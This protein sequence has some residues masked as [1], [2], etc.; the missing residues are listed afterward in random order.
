MKRPLGVELVPT[1]P[2]RRK[3]WRRHLR[4]GLGLSLC[5]LALG[6]G[7]V[8][9]L[10][11][12]EAEGSRADR[13]SPQELALMGSLQISQLR[14][15]DPDPSNRFIGNE[16]AARLGK[17]VFNDVRFSSNGKVSCASCHNPQGQFEDGRPRGL[18]V[19]EGLRRTMPS[20]GMAHSAWFFWDGRKDSLWAQALGPLEDAREHGGNRLQY[21]RLLSQHYAQPYRELFGEL[22]RLDGLPAHASPQG[23]EAERAAWA[24]I[25]EAR[26]QDINRMYANLG[27][28][29]A[30]FEARLQYGESRVDR[31]IAATLKGGSGSASLLNE[32]EMAGLRLFIGRGQC[33]TCHAGPLMTD[34]HFHNT[35]IPPLNPAQ[36]ERGRV[37]GLR[38]ALADEFNC[39]GPYSDAK[40]QQCEELRFANPK[41]PHL[42]G[43]FKTP[44][45]RNVALR[46]PYM[47]AGQFATLE[48][49][50]AHYAR[51][52]EAELGHSELREL[53]P[54]DL[55][56]QE[57][58]QLLSFLR[59]LSGP[60]LEKPAVQPA[61]A[62]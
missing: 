4:S 30:A 56:P 41:D 24:T 11:H 26:R 61:P 57:Q 38:A 29:I 53:K 35:G 58:A 32:Q 6:G 14:S 49:V 46:P 44:S 54:R 36:P 59:A 17:Q 10:A 3:G 42:V 23:S 43:A 50:L 47:H 8:L 15:P 16:A 39:L 31:Y 62:P 9:G 1:L 33:I 28:A 37:D 13:W 45:L 22:P 34:Q 7:A 51:A 5:L 27:K 2:A 40:P 60:V 18:G 19:A 20:I 48:Q 21:A 25:P 12:S 55:G 52:P